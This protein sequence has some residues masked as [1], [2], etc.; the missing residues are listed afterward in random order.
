[1]GATR[2]ALSGGAGSI[3]D[4]VLHGN[5]QDHSSP[6]ET[7]QG[8]HLECRQGSGNTVILSTNAHKGLLG[9]RHC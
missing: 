1:M 3:A 2:P 4:G 6:T 8:C 9:A 7:L 5:M